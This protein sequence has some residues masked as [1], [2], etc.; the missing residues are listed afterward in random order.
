MCAILNFDYE[1]KIASIQSI[2]DYN[3]CLL[4]AN[5]KEEYK[6]GQMLMIIII[7]LHT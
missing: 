2:G 5:R 7:K 1:R 4:C 3:N 6:V